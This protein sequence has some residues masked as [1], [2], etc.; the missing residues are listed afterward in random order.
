MICIMRGSSMH[1]D[2]Q[3]QANDLQL[4]VDQMYDKIQEIEID[5][6]DEAFGEI[7][8]IQEEIAI[9]EQRIRDLHDRGYAVQN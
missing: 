3:K 2:L 4:I 6:I 5:I 8:N 1:I 9:V 7:N